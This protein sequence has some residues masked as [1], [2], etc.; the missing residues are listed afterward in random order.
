MPRRMSDAE[1]INNLIRVL[2]VRG[3]ISEKDYSFIFGYIT[4][5]EWVELIGERR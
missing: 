5:N 1:K 4:E 2:L 3:V